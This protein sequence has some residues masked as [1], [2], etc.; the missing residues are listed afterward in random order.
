MPKLI[1]A[2]TVTSK[3]SAPGKEWEKLFFHAVGRH[4]VHFLRSVL[5]WVVYIL[6]PGIMGLAFNFLFHS[7]P[8]RSNVHIITGATLGQQTG[9]LSS[10][11]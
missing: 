3:C 11:L 1:A 8:S 10:S 4:F 9:V 7:L 5:S 2:G 6:G